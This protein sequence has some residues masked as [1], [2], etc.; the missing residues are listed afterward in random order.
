MSEVIPQLTAIERTRRAQIIEAT[1]VC[2]AVNGYSASSLA[3]IAKQAGVSKGV[4]LYHFGSKDTLIE[5]VSLIERSSGGQDGTQLTPVWRE[6]R[7][8]VARQTGSLQ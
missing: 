8:A 3:T 4:I 6:R 1:A 7:A 2:I 5:E